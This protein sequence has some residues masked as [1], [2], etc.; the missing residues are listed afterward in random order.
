M[1]T[2]N[3]ILTVLLF[4]GI[5]AFAQNK[6][7]MKI[8]KDAKEMKVKMLASNPGL[9]TYFDEAKMY[10]I[11]P[12]VGK[13]ALIVG[14]ASGNGVVYKNGKHVGMADL[15]QL[16]IG[17]QIGGEEYSEVVFLNSDNAMSDFMEN[18]LELTSQISAIAV[19]KEVTKNG[20]YDDGVAV[21]TMN[22]GGLMA[23]VSVGGQK[24]KYVP[25][26]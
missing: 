15:K 24:F 14:A 11:F 20:V 3:L 5:T 25:L 26:K 9:Q 19:N 4:V 12:N 21:Y 23:E 22:K 16:D 17:A 6:D 13:G 18:D 1:K 7:D 8:I 10:A 2:K